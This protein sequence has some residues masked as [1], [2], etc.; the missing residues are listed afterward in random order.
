MRAMNPQPQHLYSARIRKAD[1][2]ALR[3]RIG[4]E[5]KKQNKTEATQDN[6]RKNH[7]GTINK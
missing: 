1:Q 6:W 4:Q 7:S 5:K 2:W 3:M